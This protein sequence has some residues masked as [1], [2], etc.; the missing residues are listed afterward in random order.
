MCFTPGLCPQPTSLNLLQLSSVYRARTLICYSPAS[1][2]SS[3]P[4]RP[5][6]PPVLIKHKWPLP[7]LGLGGFAYPLP[8]TVKQAQAFPSLSELIDLKLIHLPSLSTTSTRLAGWIL[9]KW[10]RG[11]EFYTQRN[12]GPKWLSGQITV[13]TLGSQHIGRHDARSERPIVTELTPV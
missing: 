6:S 1:R 2:P 12:W 8:W 3:K 5:Q 10:W 11:S 4:V 7:P 13:L 9:Q